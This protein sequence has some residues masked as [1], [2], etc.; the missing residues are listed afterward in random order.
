MGDQMKL[1]RAEFVKVFVTETK[2]DA[3]DAR[4]IW[5]TT[6]MP[7]K[8]V[9][10]K[11][12]TQQAVLALHRMRQQLVKFCTM[13]INILRGLLTDGIRQGDGIRSCRVGTINMQC[14]F[15]SVAPPRMRADPIRG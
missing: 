10:M 8:E 9:A 1:M 14:L 6:K 11:T 3:A 2:N 15:K 4:A 12:E 13:Q 5:M 7:S